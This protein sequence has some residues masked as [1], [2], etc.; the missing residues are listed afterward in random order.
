MKKFFAAFFVW[1]FF[2]SDAHAQFSRY[3]VTLRNKNGT[4]YTFSNPQAY[5]SQRAIDRRTRYNISIDS[6]DL[7]VSP[8]YVNQIKGVPNV[9]VLNVSK[10]LNALTIQTSDPNAI[11]TINS[12]PFVESTSGIAAR[13]SNTNPINVDS[14]FGNDITPFDNSTAR[15]QQ[16]TAD[17]FNYG[18]NSFNEIH[19]HN[20]EFLH[21]IGLRGQGMQIAM[22]D[23]GFNN[24]TSPNFHAF[25]S[26]N[27]NNQVL[28]TW[29]FVAREQNVS[30][31]GSHGMSCF[32]TIA[33]NIP[34][35]FI[36]KA[37]KASFWLFQTEDN[38]SEYPIEEF[39]WACGAER[40]DSS[41]ADIISSSLGYSIFNNASLNHSYADMNGNITMAAI[42]GDLA[43]KRGLLVF[44]ANGN[45][46][47]SAW[48]YLITPADGDSVIAVGA[49]SSSG[50]V[51]SFSSYGPSADGQ[52]KPDL[53]SVGVGAVIQTGGG[54][55]GL[56]SGTSLACP[57]MAGLGT[58]LW[59]GFPEFNNMRIRNALWQ[60]GSIA[61]APDD[62][63]GYGIPNLKT[64]FAILLKDFSTANTALSNC[65]A[66]LTWTSKDVSGMRY[67]IE[68]KAPGDTG[69]I[70]IA[71][72]P[73]V[74]NISI[75]STHAYTK[76]DQLEDMQT[77]SYNYRVR[78]IL[79]TTTS[80]FT[81]V[82]L[83]TTTLSLTASC[84][85][86]TLKIVP[87]PVTTNQISLKIGTENSIQDLTIFFF[88]MLGQKMFQ[89]KGS[90][91]AGT[92]RFDF[93]IGRLSKGKYIVAVYDGRNL[94][95]SKGF[96]KL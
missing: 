28:G 33:A 29:D 83:D 69:Y 68:R 89:F 96:V 80:N 12:F 58:C 22:L 93:P 23:N 59:Q 21:N 26:V 81:A 78:Q 44:V 51:G 87:N 9:T 5:L 62:R 54:G 2:F 37:P 47:T 43:A 95:T 63:I 8:Y 46:G 38:A 70:K 48:H 64:A 31:D 66:T 25:D 67:E 94:L 50:A 60:S 92:A 55:I 20:G 19:L 4:P 45:S 24:F 30:D 65:T 17:H 16:I 91:S 76:T 79:D 84:V 32:S 90:K 11:T 49:V 72:V 1:G 18:T 52:V 10:W 27:A 40:A 75:L 57:N 56:S 85:K 53:A 15:V 35:Q 13:V 39:N 6:T 36:G 34:G 7:P 82:Y 88:D 61:N 41:G 14:K 73:A 3:I 86:T 71:D 77:G 74:T 42:A